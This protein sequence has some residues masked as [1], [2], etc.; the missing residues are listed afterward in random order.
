MSGVY[1]FEKDKKKHKRSIQEKGH[2]LNQI[3]PFISSSTSQS[4]G[5]EIFTCRELMTNLFQTTLSNHYSNGIRVKD[6]DP[7][8]LHNRL[9]SR[10]VFSYKLDISK[11]GDHDSSALE[12]IGKQYKDGTEGER[13]YL[14]MQKLW[15]NGFDGSTPFNIP[16]IF[17]YASNLNLLIQKKADGKL[18]SEYL[19]ED[20][21]VCRA[22]MDRVAGWLGKLHML[23]TDNEDIEV[24]KN[25]EVSIKKFADDLGE[26]YPEHASKVKDLATTLCRKVSFYENVTTTLVHG[27]FH[28]DNIFVANN[29]V[30]AIDFDQ[31]CVS[32]PARDLG[33]FIAQIRNMAF[34]SSGSMDTFNGQ[35]RCFLV[36]Y[37]KEKMP[38][39]VKPSVDRITTYAARCIF[40]C[41]YY[42][43]YT[44]KDKQSEELSI[45]LKEMELFIT[46]ETLEDIIAN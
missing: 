36:A 26:R 25:D 19:K 15:S 11:N 22:Q 43:F 12:L 37:L 34:H 32:D 14:A 31:L 41:I 16:E 18:L 23:E 28:P 29:S 6:C 46:E 5:M 13:T 24:H 33:Y 20:D 2:A 44:F 9:G 35:I 17:C 8:V 21:S 30:T 10:Q 27:D 1:Y 42:M 3:D 39:K 7:E 40:E 4:T 38:E 45:W